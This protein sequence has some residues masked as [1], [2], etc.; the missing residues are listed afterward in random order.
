M[1]NAQDILNI[2]IRLENNG[3]KTYLDARQHTADADLKALL[4]W[5]A[6]EEQSHARWFTE[7]KERLSRGE[8]HHLMAEF[9]SALVDDVVR[10]QAFS[11]QEVDFATIDTP[12]KMIRTFLGFENDTIGFYEI[13][14]SFIQDPTIAEQL[15]QVI[16]EEKNHVDQFQAMLARTHPL[17]TAG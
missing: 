10:E 1:F 2:A 3:E 11:L 12:E 15:E 9:S 8:D 4:A 13:L 14:K 17:S 16:A 7:L 6:Q 5:I